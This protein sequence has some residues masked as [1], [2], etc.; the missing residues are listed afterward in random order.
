MK[1]KLIIFALLL[2]F[3]GCNK[4]KT[5][6]QPQTPKISVEVDPNLSMN[7]TVGDSS[8]TEA[9]ATEIEIPSEVPQYEIK[10]QGEIKYNKDNDIFGLTDA[11]IKLYED[12]SK[13]FDKTIFKDVDPKT[14]FKLWITAGIDKAWETEY[15]LYSE[16]SVKNAKLT[17]QVFYNNHMNDL[18]L[19]KNTTRKQVAEFNFS[20][21]DEGT[22]TENEDGTGKLEFPAP[23]IA[24]EDGTKESQRPFT[25]N[26][27]KN[28][29]GYW[30]LV[31]YPIS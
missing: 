4:Q 19:E 21:V 30:E 14:I 16:E 31:Y 17:E 22:W 6:E 3:T 23:D 18:K 5:T 20:R 25:V 8:N 24:R 10:P 1:K 7:A 9:P 28:L 2:S 11:E 29:G 15:K 26:Y 13:N 27:S 12:F